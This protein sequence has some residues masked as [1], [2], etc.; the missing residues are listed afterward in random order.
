MRQRGFTLMELIGVIAVI[1]I[2]SAVIAPNLFKSVDDALAKA[3][4][5]NLETLANGLVSYS[6]QAKRLPSR[7]PADWAAVIANHVAI[8]E[9][10][11]LV[12][13]RGF[14]RA[15]YF[16][17]RFF[18]SSDS[19]FSGY[20]Q[21]SGLT[22]P[23]VS[24]RAIFVSDLTRNAPARP[25]TS[26]AFEAIW[27]QDPGASVLAGP[28]VHIQRI[29]FASLFHRLVLNNQ[30]TSQPAYSL[31]SGSQSAVPAASGGLDG[32]VT[33]YVMD[34]TELR[35][36]QAPF[37]SGALETSSLVQVDKHYRYGTDGTNWFWGRP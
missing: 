29:S 26:A 23:P 28:K 13:R 37:P 17:P 31:E 5:G 21:T 4:K 10:E 3:E 36:Y 16:D 1:A 2:L 12:N 33:R 9:S 27:D 34:G 6:R 24:P 14:N 22:A 7:T 32:M 35:L 30:N 25:T 20:Q 11:V 15:L 18:T 19:N 8:P